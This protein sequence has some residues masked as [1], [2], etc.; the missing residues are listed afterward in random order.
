MWM[1]S[2]F[3]ASEEVFCTKIGATHPEE[4]YIVGAQLDGRGPHREPRCAI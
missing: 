4:M 3:C 1:V 2:R